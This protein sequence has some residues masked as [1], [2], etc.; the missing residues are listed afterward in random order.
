VTTDDLVALSERHFI[1]LGVDYGHTEDKSCFFLPSENDAAV[2]VTPDEMTYE[3]GEVWPILNFFIPILDEVD[4]DCVDAEALMRLDAEMPFG[5][6]LLSFED[7]V[8]GVSHQCV[9][10]P[11]AVEYR[12]AIELLIG[13]AE[14]IRGQLGEAVSGKAPQKYSELVS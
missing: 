9:G 3:S 1:Q 2:I 10:W 7:Q 13:A 6:L 11:G 4:L 8:L 14:R 5:A 12:V